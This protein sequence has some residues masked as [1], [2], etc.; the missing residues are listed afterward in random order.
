MLSRQDLWDIYRA[1]LAQTYR[2][3][4]AARRSKVSLSDMLLI[5]RL[6]RRL[7]KTEKAMERDRNA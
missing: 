3:W 6:H 5:A 2:L 4:R 1:G 7:H